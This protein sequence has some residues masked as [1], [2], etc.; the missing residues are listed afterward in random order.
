MVVVI[1]V[2]RI[3]KTIIIV[4]VPGFQNLRIFKEFPLYPKDGLNGED[5]EIPATSIVRCDAVYGLTVVV[6]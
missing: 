3:V 2:E 1:V 4:S 6:F 5:V